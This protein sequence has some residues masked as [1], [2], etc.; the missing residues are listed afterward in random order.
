MRRAVIKGQNLYRNALRQRRRTLVVV[1]IFSAIIN[2]LMLTG[3]IYM[4]QIY[5]RVL[6]S[7]S[8]PTL[9]GLFIIVVILYVFLGFYQFLRSRLLSRAGYRLDQNLGGPA[10][11]FWMQ[12]CLNDQSRRHNPVRDLSVVRSFLS[13]P[14]IMGVFDV[15]WIPLFLIVIFAI[16]P[17]LGYLTLAGAGVM[18]AAAILNQV[19]TKDSTSVS[20]QREELENEF[21]ESSGRNAAAVMTQGMRDA[22]VL[23]WRQLHDAALAK[24]QEGIDRTE[25]FS[26]FSRSF[27][28]LLQSALLT[29]GAYLALRQEITPGMI[30]A[31]SIIAGRALAPID[32]VLGQWRAIS[33]GMAA[34]KR[35]LSAFDA[36]PAETKRLALPEPKGHLVVRSLVKLMPPQSHIKGRQRILNQVSFELSPGDGLGVIG[37]SA[38]GKSSLAKLL[39][40]AWRPDAGDVRLDGAALDQWRPEDLG[41][42]IGYLPQSVEVLP[43]TIAENISRFDPHPIDSDIVEA[44]KTAGVHDMIL[45]FPNGYSTAIG[46]RAQPLSS[47]QVQQLGLARA[48]YR[49]PKLVVLDE[50][51]SNLDTDGDDAMSFAIQTLRDHGS[52]VI[53]MAHRPSALVSLNKLLLLREGRV[54]Y[55]GDK[56]DTIRAAIST[57]TSPRAASESQG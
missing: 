11:T 16:H 24:G 43:G 14:A 25:Y 57:T 20:A 26:S 41:R 10:M 29:V 19:L 35:L 33:R 52:V 45:T 54:A 30:I 47:G 38:A 53:V 23:R 28:L 18:I 44:A 46:A 51:N 31:T 17:W 37:N 42:H 22:I 56:E 12:E 36:M 27:R 39:V 8:I 4:L 5:D 49:L 34:H 40:G 2:V 13:S 9:Q 15:P 6:S 50:P 32:Q 21:L 7:G 55:F 48:V 1:G 3:P